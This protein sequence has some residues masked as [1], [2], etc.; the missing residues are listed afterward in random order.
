MLCI[1]TSKCVLR[2]PFAGWNQLF[3]FFLYFI[4]CFCTALIYFWF[5]CVFASKNWFWPANGMRSTRSLVEIHNKC[6]YCVLYVIHWYEMLTCSN[7]SVCLFNTF[8]YVV[9]ELSKW[10]QTFFYSHL[11]L[12]QRVDDPA[13]GWHKAFF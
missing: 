1:S 11:M 8:R 9:D 12:R 13:V 7:K 5:I 10:R 4:A 3:A 2:T 6:N